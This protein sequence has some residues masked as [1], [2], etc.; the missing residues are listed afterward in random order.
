VNGE[1]F[2]AVRMEPPASGGY[3]GVLSVRRSSLRDDDHTLEDGWRHAEGCSCDLC[4]ADV[5]VPLEPAATRAWPSSVS[6]FREAAAPVSGGYMPHR[7]D[8]N[9]PVSCRRN[10]DETPRHGRSRLTTV[11]HGDGAKPWTVQHDYSHAT[12]ARHAFGRFPKPVSKSVRAIAA[13]A[14]NPFPPVLAAD[15]GNGRAHVDN[16]SAPVG[17]LQEI[18]A[19]YMSRRPVRLRTNVR[20]ETLPRR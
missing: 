16:W 4:T 14:A 1:L 8:S 10:A 12:T 9:E 5:A 19:C 15:S 3:R 13:K 2:R 17:R 7:L 6:A 18:R 11:E 20:L